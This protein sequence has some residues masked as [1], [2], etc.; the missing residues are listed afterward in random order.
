MGLAPSACSG[1]R[2]VWRHIRIGD[3]AYLPR[4]KRFAAVVNRFD[5][6]SGQMARRRAALRFERVLKAQVHGIDLAAKDT[7]LSLLAIQFAG[8]EE[9]AGQVTLIFSGQAAIRLQV[10][11]IEAEMKDLGAAWETKSKPEHA[12]GDADHATAGAVAASLAKPPKS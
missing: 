10:E 5:W 7:V 12:G 4:E 6:A 1:L 8:G 9:P 2:G 11:C 3:L